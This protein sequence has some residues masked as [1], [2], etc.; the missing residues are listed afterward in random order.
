MRGKENNP[1][2]NGVVVFAISGSYNDV[3]F[4]QYCDYKNIY[5]PLTDSFISLTTRR[6]DSVYKNDRRTVKSHNCE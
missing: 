2:K 6:L 3:T 4:A 1:K 5:L